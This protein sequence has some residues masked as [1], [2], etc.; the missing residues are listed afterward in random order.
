LIRS[1]ARRGYRFGGSV[2]EVERGAGGRRGPGGPET[3]LPFV[4]RDDKLGR[5]REAWQKAAAGRGAVVVATGPPGIGKTRLA[6]VFARELEGRGPVVLVGRSREGEGVP[7]LWPWVQVLRGL[8]ADEALR[9][10]VRAAPGCLD[11]LAD[12]VPELAG[13]RAPRAPR[14]EL[15]PEQRRF[16]LL[17]AVAAALVAASRQRPLLVVLEDL[18]WAG[19]PALR[20]LEHLAFELAGQPIL[21]L[22]TVREEPRAHGHPLTRTLAVLRRLDR[23]EE[24]AL[25]GLGLADVETLA[26]RALGR[27]V[28]PALLREIHDRT[29]GVPLFVCEA[30]RW[31]AERGGIADPERIARE[32][33]PLPAGA[34][35]FLRRPL[36]SLSPACAGLLGAASVLGREFSLPLLAAAAEL[37]RDEALDLLDEAARAGVVEAAPGSPLAWRFSHALF[38]EAVYHDLP[39]GA[40]ARLHHRAA[41]RLEELHAGATDAVVA[42]I[43]DHRHRGLAVGDAERAYASALRAAERAGRLFAGE[44]M[45]AHLQQALAALELEQPAGGARRLDTLLALGDA[46]RLAGDRRRRRDVFVRTLEAARA[47]GAPLALARA[48]IGLCDLGEWGVRDGAA[49]AAVGEALARVGEAPGVERARLLTRLAYLD[50]LDAPGRAG[51]IAREAVELAR[52]LGDPEALQDALYVLHFA[53]GGPD[54]CEE[55]GGLL[56]EL[57]RAAPGAPSPD[58]AVIA[59]LDVASDRLGL[60]DAAGAAALRAETT[61]LA[62]ERPPLAARWHAG[63]Y[64]TGLALL[65][66][67]FDEVDER[68]RAAFELGQRILHPY[69]PGCFATHRALLLA[70]RGERRAAEAILEPQLAARQGPV[71]W[72]RAF[73]ARL[74]LALGRADEA[75]AT[76]EELAA[77][78]FGAIPRNLRWTATLVEIAHLC[79]ELGDAGRSAALRELL[80]PHEHRHAVMA[81]AVCYG[82]P[83]GFALARL[84]E[85]EGRLD[86]A[87]ERLAEA[88]EAA[89]ALGARPM[90]ARVE[91]ALGRLGARRRERGRAREHLEAAARAAEGL[92]MAGLAVE[93]RALLARA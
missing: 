35:A 30:L 51:P 3:D 71:A 68:A 21:V 75:R 69:A 10:Q 14:A 60:G 15:V 38:R 2:V 67:R 89:A 12:L 73:T 86:L 28:P 50:L 61:E 88:R 29:E 43:A 45:A 80:A 22:G 62:G 5:L 52:R 70:E 4:G 56:P 33:L 7:P 91:L 53:L 41:E 63:V 66:G 44:A 8:V 23:S 18:Q 46:L 93:A 90:A 9:E 19:A 1:V 57:A 83:V 16:L 24:L 34:L 26:R 6:E 59:L 48:A 17:D 84:D 78:G 25:G 47:A 31:I 11:E 77:P 92:G 36:E 87:A 58:R 54:D 27:P 65:E 81:M 64:D 37:S 55:R 20:L 79:A 82:G 42:E 40:R 32:G 39:P 13:A 85:L 74:R 76:L 72:L 49:R